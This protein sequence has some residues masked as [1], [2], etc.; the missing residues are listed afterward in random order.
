[1]ESNLAGNA[2]RYFRVLKLAS[3]YGLSLEV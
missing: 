3:E 2:G 1:M